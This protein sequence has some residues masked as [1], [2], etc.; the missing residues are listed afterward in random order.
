MISRPSNF[1]RLILFGVFA[2]LLL[3]AAQAQPWVSFETHSRYLALGDS[4]SAG[5]GAI[6]A[7]QGFVHQLYQSGAIDNINNT[8]FCNM[9]V[10]NAVSKDVL[11]YQ[12]PQVKRFFSVTGQP[13]RKVIT[14]T[15]GGNDMMQVLGGADPNVVLPAFGANLFAILSTL[16]TEFPDARIYVANY[17]DPR[18]PVPNEKLL[19]MGLNQVIGGVVAAFPGSVTLVDVFTAFEGRNGLL[20]IERKGGDPFQIHPTNAGYRVMADLFASAIRQ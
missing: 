5:Y 20:L 11:D 4:I 17:C 16:T 15:V 12:V 1:H 7:T 3:P 2:F 6:P 19:V 14:L 9:G 8:L 18:P 13:Y 10:P